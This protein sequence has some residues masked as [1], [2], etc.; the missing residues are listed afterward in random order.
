MRGAEAATNGF[1]QA[2]GTQRMEARL[3]QIA[4]EIRP[5]EHPFANS[6]RAEIIRKRLERGIVAPDAQ[7]HLPLLFD[8]QAQMAVELLNAG[9]TEESIEELNRLIRVLIA[10]ETFNAPNRSSLRTLLATA[11][12]RLAEQQNC[13]QG[14]TVDSC[15]LPIQGGGIHKL[16]LGSRSAIRVLEDQLSEFPKDLRARWLL[17]LA[18]MTLGEHP[19]Q[20]P[21]AWLIPSKVFDSDY[22]IRRFP[23][24]A[25]RLG[26]DL[27]T[28][29]GS[30]V[31]DDFD[32][33]GYLDLMISAR[34]E[35][36][37]LRFFHNNADGSF[38]ERT[39]EA[40]LTGELGGLNL[41]QADYN[42][43][44]H[45]DLLILRGAWQGAQGHHPN[46][47]L[48]NNGN[49]TFDDVTEEA[50]LLSFHP[51]QAAVWFDYNGDGWLDVFVGN[52]TTPGDTNRCE[53]FR[54]NGDG[55]F[56]ECARETG[57]DL[58]G[59]VKAVGCGDYD[60]DGR[61]DL[62]ISSRGEAK[63]LLHN[64]GP[65]GPDRSPRARWHF[66][67]RAA[68]AGVIEPRHSFP[69]WFFD[70]D[71]DG[72]P[73]IF[74]CGYGIT[75]VGDVAADYLGL[76]NGAERPRLYHNNHD[77]T[78]S[79]VSGAAHLDHV[80]IAMAGNFGD[81]D[82]DGWLDFYLGTGDPD[83]A[84]LVPNRMF[85]NS[86]GRLFQDVTTS[87]GFGHLQK[88]HGIAF[89]DLDNDGDQDVYEVMGGALE[90]DHYRNVLFENPGHGNHWITLR[91]E[92]VQSNRSAIGARIRVVV[93]TGGVERS[94]Y[95]TVSTGG[96][97]GGS[98]LRQEIGL[99]KA[100]SIRR[101]EV[102]WPTTGQ[103][104]TVRDL[105]MD[106]FYRLREGAVSA[107]GVELKTFRLS[108]GPGMQMLHEH[109]HAHP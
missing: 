88:G 37:P 90:G 104:Q 106:H 66:S 19:A 97:F 109:G 38:T 86:E 79:D 3:R 39:R 74:V 7:E 62:F 99:G 73:D 59:Y 69:T 2:A 43:D 85:R 82:N 76:P 23:D 92:G 25:G 24:I 10:K 17:N 55:T 87:G 58:L 54:N 84:T 31:M 50:G 1:Y 5:M 42:N 65:Q 33:D 70:Y 105:S 16:P 15:I 77:G 96:S 57:V 108:G 44:G 4:R 101:V 93:D 91:L 46:S 53:L 35:L 36:D 63:M 14:H 8:L 102:F 30:V 20:V 40:G 80:L 29:S 107:Q 52:E 100:Q 48:R 27:D 22:D 81:L 49:G 9:R 18:Y 12:L 98:P 67:D 26:L 75:N 32:G 34:G 71:N 72:W 6:R 60:N 61:P 64:D 47:L 11:Y 41:V 45:L 83:L 89:G 56:T 68:A 95:K 13:L 28:L 51:T 78:F 103:T 21:E 94:I